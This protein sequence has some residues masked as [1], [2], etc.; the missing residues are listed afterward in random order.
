[1]GITYSNLS[2]LSGQFVFGLQSRQFEGENLANA[3][4]FTTPV[5]NFSMN[6]E[7]RE[8]TSVG[9]VLSRVVQ[10][11]DLERGLTYINNQLELR[12]RQQLFGRVDFNLGLAYQFIEYEGD[13]P[14]GRNDQYVAFTPSISYTFWKDQ[15]TWSIFYRRQQLTSDNS[16]RDYEVNALGTGLV[17][18][19]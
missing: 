2:K 5:I 10:I 19:F 3:K 1:M 15:I 6:Y 9:L 17:F 12:L 7:L 4:D 14:D 13:G 11:S 16:I 18:Q 8:M